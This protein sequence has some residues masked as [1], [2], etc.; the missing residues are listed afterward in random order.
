MQAENDI[1][2][3]GTSQRRADRIREV[4]NM[5]TKTT[6][7]KHTWGEIEELQRIDGIFVALT[8]IRDELAELPTPRPFDGMP[9]AMRS[10]IKHLHGERK[11][12]E[13][14]AKDEWMN[15]GRRILYLAKL[16]AAIA[17]AEGGAA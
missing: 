7:S 5:T 11:R 12:L 14:A 15:R 9:C 13:A 6:E 2:D 17:K 10:R 16:G 8:E 1:I 4:R 3:L